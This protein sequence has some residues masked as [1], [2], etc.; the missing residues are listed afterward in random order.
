M[1]CM[2]FQVFRKIITLLY[3]SRVRNVLTLSCDYIIGVSH[4]GK[5]VYTRRQWA[6]KD[7]LTACNVAINLEPAVSVIQGHQYIVPIERR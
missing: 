5:I 1:C 6:D 7:D 3:G 4:A 2:T